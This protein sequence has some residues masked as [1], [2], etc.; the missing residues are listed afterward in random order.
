[1]EVASA[2]VDAIGAHKTGLR[3]SPYGVFNDT[4]EFDGVDEQ[5]RYIAQQMSEMS[6]VYIHMVDHSKMGYT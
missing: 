5:Y 6:L 2:V 4:G 1:V 3:I